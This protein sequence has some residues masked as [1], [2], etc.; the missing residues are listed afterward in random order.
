MSCINKHVVGKLCSECLAVD[1]EDLVSRHCSRV[2]ADDLMLDNDGCSFHT[3]AISA[4]VEERDR[5]SNVSAQKLVL[6]LYVGASSSNV[7][8]CQLER[9]LCVDSLQRA[10]RAVKVVF[11]ACARVC[12]ADLAF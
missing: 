4:V 2:A 8:A 1:G 7:V 10:M 11:D 5:R 6:A 9:A 3:D 12:F